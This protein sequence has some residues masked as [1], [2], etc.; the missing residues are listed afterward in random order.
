MPSVTGTVLLVQESRIRV[1]TADGRG[2]VF[3]LAHDAPI[4]PQDLPPLTGQCVEVE[5]DE[6]P[7]LVA[8]VMRDIRLLPPSRLRMSVSASL[9]AILLGVALVLSSLSAMA[10]DRAGGLQ[11]GQ[12]HAKA[13][14]DR[15]VYDAEG[16]EVGEIEDLV[17]DP[18]SGRAL[19]AI[20]EIEGRLGFRERYVA[21][22]LD[23]LRTGEERRIILGMTREELRALP[24]FDYRQ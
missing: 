22:P 8:G 24:G 12:I 11:P 19:S 5:Y 13:L 14:I 6:S 1:L 23:R 17:L 21:V 18:A 20:V 15:N 3:L 4:E 16:T 2:L 10:Q 7:Q 9:A